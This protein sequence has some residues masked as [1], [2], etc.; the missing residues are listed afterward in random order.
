[1]KYKIIYTKTA[2][3]V[4]YRDT[5]AEAEAIAQRMKRYGY[6]VSIWEITAEGGRSIR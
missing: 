2:P 6:T 3:A 1:M 5:L 4:T